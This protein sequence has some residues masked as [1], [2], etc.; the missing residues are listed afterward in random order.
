MY[1]ASLKIV[2]NTN[3]D[4]L[5]KQKLEMALKMLNILDE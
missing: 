2:I 5:S 3:L 4:K 1:K